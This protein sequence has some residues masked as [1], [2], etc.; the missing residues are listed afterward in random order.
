MPPVL[1]VN[2][3]GWGGVGRAVKCTKFDVH[4]KPLSP[5]K[6]ALWF[7]EGATYRRCRKSTTSAGTGITDNLPQF[8]SHISPI[9]L[10]I[11][12][13]WAGVKGDASVS[14]KTTRHV[15]STI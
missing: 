6:Q 14:E 12:T 8:D 1:P 7:R 2:F 15:G 9:S 11:F 4:F 3:A 13:A 10:P 5:A